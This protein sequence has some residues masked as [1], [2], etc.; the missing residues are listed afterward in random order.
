MRYEFFSGSKCLPRGDYPSGT[1]EPKRR[2]EKTVHF[3]TVRQ[4]PYLS[5]HSINLESWTIADHSH[6]LQDLVESSS[7]LS[8]KARKNR[9]GYTTEP[10][11]LVRDLDLSVAVFKFTISFR[12]IGP[13]EQMLRPDVLGPETAIGPRPSRQKD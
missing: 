12:Q 1:I 10:P 8:P 5:D 4:F 7:G 13:T 9:S 6:Y 3:Q 2:S 11:V